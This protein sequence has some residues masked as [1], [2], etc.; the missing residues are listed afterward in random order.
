MKKLIDQLFERFTEIKEEQVLSNTDLHLAT[1][2]LLVEVAVSD[3]SFDESERVQLKKLLLSECQLSEADVDTLIHDAENASDKASSLFE[4]THI[5]NKH[6]EYKQKLSLVNNLWKVAYADGE[7]DKHE[8]HS[9]RK[10]ADLIHVSHRDF[11]LEK[12]SVRENG[13]N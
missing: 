4:F 3:L 5:I 2:A 6:C 8:E 7:L 11:I 9:I 1:A 13:E 12:I 10:I